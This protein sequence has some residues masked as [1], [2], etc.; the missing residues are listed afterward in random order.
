MQAISS[1]VVHWFGP[2][3]PRPVAP[4]HMN[5]LMSQAIAAPSTHHAVVDNQLF[6]NFGNGNCV[7]DYAHL[8]VLK[9]QNV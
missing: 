6:W 7:N 3:L 2:I 8:I 9:F 5:E 1:N 4:M